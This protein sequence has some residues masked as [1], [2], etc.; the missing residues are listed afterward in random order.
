MA[1][2]LRISRTSTSPVA[3]LMRSCTSR[4]PS[5]STRATQSLLS[6]IA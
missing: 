3:S 4:T 5:A 2:A 1:T 6:T